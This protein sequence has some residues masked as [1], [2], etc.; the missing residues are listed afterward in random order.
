MSDPAS[1]LII[2]LTTAP[3]VE[4]GEALAR[5]LVDERLAACVSVSAPMTSIYRWQGAVETSTE[6]QLIIKAARA[7]WPAIEARVKALHPYDVPELLVLAVEDG[8]DAYVRWVAGESS[9]RG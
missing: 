8:S 2:V 9:S 7:R 3:S 5:A 4:Q 1:R 6:C